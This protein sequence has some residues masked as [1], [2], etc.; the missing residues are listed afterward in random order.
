ML[1]PKICAIVQ[2]QPAGAGL[3]LPSTRRGRPCVSLSRA[4]QT[5]SAGVGTTDSRSL[6]PLTA[7]LLIYTLPDCERC[8]RLL[9]L[10]HPPSLCSPGPRYRTESYHKVYRTRR[11]RTRSTGE[12]CE[13]LPRYGLR[14]NRLPPTRHLAGRTSYR[15]RSAEQSDTA[16]ATM[17]PHQKNKVDVSVRSPRPC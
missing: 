2:A 16:A 14:L 8:S 6:P 12:H 10:V 9:S 17:N 13:E 15:H 3:Q 4:H 5:N 11:W 7:A 1:R